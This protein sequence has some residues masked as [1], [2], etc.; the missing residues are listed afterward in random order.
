[1]PKFSDDDLAA[2]RLRMAEFHAAHSTTAAAKKKS[3]PKRSRLFRQLGKTKPRAAPITPVRRA[4][5]TPVLAETGLGS[6]AESKRLVGDFN[7][8]IDQVSKVFSAVRNCLPADNDRSRKLGT[9]MSNLL[10]GLRQLAPRMQETM[11][12]IR[13]LTAIDSMRWR[14]TPYSQIG[15]LTMSSVEAGR[16]GQLA[17]RLARTPALPRPSVDEEVEALRG[18]VAEEVLA[19]TQATSPLAELVQIQAA[20]AA[21]YA[22]FI[23]SAPSHRRAELGTQ[24]HAM[25]QLQRSVASLRE[26]APAPPSMVLLLDPLASHSIVPQ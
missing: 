2:K 23:R 13:T 6:E 19:V 21:A 4:A 9:R 26:E 5:S 18:S 14:T 1:M 7:H 17:K 24:L 11:Q 10:S 22:T 8:T 20:N 12:A 16:A 25:R 3:K 15:G